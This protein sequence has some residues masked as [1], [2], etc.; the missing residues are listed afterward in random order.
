MG[1]QKS[2]TQLSGKTTAMK[3]NQMPYAK[4]NDSIGKAQRKNNHP[5]N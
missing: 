4:R 1:L 5:A 2:W 3:Q